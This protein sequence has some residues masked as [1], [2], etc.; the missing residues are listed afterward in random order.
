MT[1][2]H[3]LIFAA[4]RGERMTLDLPAGEVLLIDESW[5]MVGSANLD[6]RSFHRNYELNVVVDSLDFGAQVVGGQTLLQHERERQGD[7]FRTRHRQVVDGAVNRQLA[8]RAAREPDWLHDEAVSGHRSAVDGGSV[9]EL[10]EAEGGREQPFDQR[11][12][13]F[14]SGAVR[15]RDLLVSEPGR[16]GPHTLDQLESMLL[17]HTTAR[18]RA[19]RP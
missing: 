15:H 16:L 18:S 14:S 17:T 4:G 12:G 2:R 3:A 5:A 19:K 6:Q 9:A 13:R 10:V 7:R 8:D 11:R 1:I